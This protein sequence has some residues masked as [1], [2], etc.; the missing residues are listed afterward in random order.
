MFVWHTKSSDDFVLDPSVTQVVLIDHLGGFDRDLNCNVL[1]K[2]NSMD[3]MIDVYCEYFFDD[4]VKQKYQNLNLYFDIDLWTEQNFVTTFENHKIH[5]DIAFENFLC[6]FAGVNHV[7]R[8]LL[9]AHL[10]KIGWFNPEYSTKN[11]AY[12]DLEIDGDIQMLQ[13]KDF[14]HKFFIDETNFKQKISSVSYNTINHVN[15]IKMLEKSITSSFVHL[16]G[17]TVAESHVPFV[18]EKFLY[19]VVNRGIF[20]GFGQPGWHQFLQKNLGFCLYKTLFDYSFDN[21][22]NALDRILAITSML[23]KYSTLGK[24]D[25]HDLYLLEKDNIEYNY[26]HYFSRDYIQ[27]LKTVTY[28]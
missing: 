10:N 15:N 26:D 16:V 28:R 27:S 20:V 23:F 19:S 7:S 22:T 25:L 1:H 13:G 14:Y 18:T 6:T 8:R 4:S 24:N 3:R 9:L 5:Q 2:L 11:F 17:E 21:I 12:T